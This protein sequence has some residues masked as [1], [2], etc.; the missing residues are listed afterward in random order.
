MKRFVTM[1]L[2]AL[3]CAGG[4]LAGAEVFYFPDP[5]SPLDGS[6]FALQY[7]DNTQMQFM[8]EEYVYADAPEGLIG[9]E[10]ADAE[11]ENLW[12]AGLVL[13]ETP[14]AY[15]QAF[16]DVPMLKTAE[17]LYAIRIETQG[18]RPDIVE[19]ITLYHPGA[20]ETAAEANRFFSMNFTDRPYSDVTPY[21][22]PGFER[23]EIVL[24]PGEKYDET[25][26]GEGP[27]CQTAIDVS[28]L[29]VG[30]STEV[31]AQ[32]LRGMDEPFMFNVTKVA[33][34]GGAAE[35]TKE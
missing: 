34:L 10:V 25:H 8:P 4:A 30:E 16:S 22:V 15:L 3:L 1:A 19:E 29:S 6:Y 14:T 23:F 7:K 32:L 17:A 27:F 21:V 31:Y 5:G 26:G 11:E 33:L 20:G 13:Y 9:L 18:I 12:L 28:E 35:E 2:A 24:S